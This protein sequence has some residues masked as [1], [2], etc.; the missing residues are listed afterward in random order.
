MSPWA[1]VTA[2]A[3]LMSA[4]TGLIPSGGGSGPQVALAQVPPGPGPPPGPP[5]F[6]IQVQHGRGYVYVPL[7]SCCRP[8]DPSGIPVEPDPPPAPSVPSAPSAPARP[9]SGDWGYLRM[10]VEP[11]DARV[12]IDGRELGAARQLAGPQQFVALT[13]GLHRIDLALPGFKSATAVVEIAPRR[14]HLLRLRLTPDPDTPA[15][16]PGSRRG[17]DVTPEATPAGGGYFVVPRR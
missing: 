14:S 16:H 2:S 13:P 4:L 9:S 12:S 5:G 1:R 3:A 11:P 8:L 15:T 17:E 10:E 7:D 6:Y